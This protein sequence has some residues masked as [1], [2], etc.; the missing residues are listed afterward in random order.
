MELG[1]WCNATWFVSLQG[2]R[3]SWLLKISWFFSFVT[4]SVAIA[5]RLERQ[6]IAHW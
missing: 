3:L 2:H 1:V 5:P 6:F 4:G